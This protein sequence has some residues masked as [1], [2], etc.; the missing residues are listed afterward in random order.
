MPRIE[1]TLFALSYAVDQQ[2]NSLSVF[3][4]IEEIAVPPEVPEPSAPDQIVAVG[5]TFSLIN[6][7][8]RSEP[9]IPEERFVRVQVKVPDGRVAALTEFKLDLRGGQRSRTINTFKFLPFTGTGDY[10]FAIEVKSGEDTWQNVLE[11][12][13]PV[14]RA[15]TP[16]E[17]VG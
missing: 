10:R 9:E 5:P 4:V 15:P 16:A 7:W 17:G 8:A 2:S 12:I 1:W 14:R 13:L 6:M 3:N 11:A